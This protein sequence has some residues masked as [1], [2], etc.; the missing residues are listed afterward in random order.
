MEDEIHITDANMHEGWG[1]RRI[2]E[3][4]HSKSVIW[5]LRLREITERHIRERWFRIIEKRHNE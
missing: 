2:K 4:W 5:M 3:E 1:W